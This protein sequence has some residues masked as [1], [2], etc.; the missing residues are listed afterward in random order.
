MGIVLPPQVI[1]PPPSSF[2]V[3]EHGPEVHSNVRMPQNV[4]S[5]LASA[6]KGTNEKAVNAKIA[7]NFFM[8]NLYLN[9]ML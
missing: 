5:Q 2:T 8:C 4:P 1:D 3:T 6:V 9:K 7:N